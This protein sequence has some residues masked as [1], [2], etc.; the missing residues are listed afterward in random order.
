V[1]KRTKKVLLEELDA[2][3]SQLNRYLP[4]SRN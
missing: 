3:Q 4:S 1:V 2:S